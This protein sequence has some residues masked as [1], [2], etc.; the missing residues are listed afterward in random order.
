MPPAS[1]ILYLIKLFRL[2]IPT[3][4]RLRFSPVFW[5]LRLPFDLR[6]RFFRLSFSVATRLL[7]LTI[8]V[9]TLCCQSCLCLATFDCIL[10]T[11]L[12]AFFQR[13]EGHIRFFRTLERAD[14]PKERRGS[15]EPGA[16][17]LL[18]CL[19]K[20]ALPGKKQLLKS[21]HELEVVVIDVTET[22][23][24]RPKKAVRPR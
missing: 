19:A 14:V 11:A 18:L 24:E 20:L 17:F 10:D 23:I 8:S 5:V 3:S 21:N 4:K 2:P 12:F 15:P 6:D 7:Q 9:A 13:L 1:V 16:R 22:P